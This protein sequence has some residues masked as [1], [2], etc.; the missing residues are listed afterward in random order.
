MHAA[1][2]LCISPTYHLLYIIAAELSRHLEISRHTCFLV[3]GGGGCGVIRG[4]D[5]TRT[6]W[7]FQRHSIIGA[8]GGKLLIEADEV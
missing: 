4:R 1:L 7:R 5:L 3:G 2:P 8:V 6:T